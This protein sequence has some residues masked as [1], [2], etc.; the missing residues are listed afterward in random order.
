MGRL[1]RYIRDFTDNC[2][3]DF[4]DSS[5]TPIEESEI[6]KTFGQ[7]PASTRARGYYYSGSTT[8]YVPQRSYWVSQPSPV[9]M[10]MGSEKA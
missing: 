4:D 5:V 2:W 6:E 9:N 7:D 8:A 1:R 3:Y 10:A